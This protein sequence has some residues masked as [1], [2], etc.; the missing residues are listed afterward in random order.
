MRAVS[1][2]QQ[3]HARGWTVGRVAGA[4]IILTPSM[5]VLAVVLTLVVTPSIRSQAPELGGGIY[6]VA[7]AF[8]VLLLVSVL[9]HEIA[10]GVVARARGQQP[11][12]F[13]LTLWGGHTS[14]GGLA[15][16]PA[17][18][19]LVA[20]VGPLANLVLAAACFGLARVVDPWSVAA[21]LLYSGAVT[22]GFV[23]VFNLLPGL[24]L[25]GGRV[26]EA[27]V[28]AATGDRHRGTVAAAWVGRAVAVAVVA[29][30]LAV[31]VV[32]GRAPDLFSVVWGVLIGGFLWSGASASLRGAQH[33]RAAEAL[34]IDA[35]G[36]RA[37]A[38]SHTQSVAEAGAAAAAAGA[39][40]VVLL[41]PDGRPAAY[42]DRASA[43]AVPPAQ[44]PTTPVTSVS[45]ALPVGAVVDAS[46]SGRALLEA[47]AGA[48]QL[49][50][51]VVGLVDGRVV[52]L[53]RMPDVVRA[54]DPR[55]ARAA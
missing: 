20:I 7:A 3:E 18:N 37:V 25:D 30:V 10:H 2:P 38:V 29:W 36:T 33:G 19:A 28:W 24:P 51:V 32:E 13:V 41:S 6:L 31:P 34:S 9:V 49:S 48:M 23:A 40:E 45:V 8:V 53:V 46:L 17:T 1:T 12:E 4:P 35:V 39:A 26:L 55:A 50:P 16:T 5:L 27:A 11:F 43:A 22:N 21:L 47:L 42:V 15:P 44:Q 14:F 52:A 54:L